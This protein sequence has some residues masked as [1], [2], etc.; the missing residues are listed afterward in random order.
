MAA[1]NSVGSKAR[2]EGAISK[3]G[4]DRPVVWSTETAFRHLKSSGD[5]GAD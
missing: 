3:L 5:V 1:D 4:L 2:G